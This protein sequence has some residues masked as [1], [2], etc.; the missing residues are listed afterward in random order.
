MR[1]L[2]N[3]IPFNEVTTYREMLLT[4]PF[5]Y[6]EVDSPGLPTTGMVHDFSP[7][8]EIYQKVLSACQKAFPEIADKTPYRAYLNLFMPHEKPFF[9]TD[10]EGITIL[11]YLNPPSSYD[12]GGETQFISQGNCIQG[13]LP[14]PG[15][16]V[17]FNALLL[18]R[19]TSFRTLT[20]LT[21]A[22]KYA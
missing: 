16:A 2:D 3:I 8:D 19:A 20:R 6:G 4:Y 7:D 1:Y 13:V 17:I 9:H 10:G 5:K 12:E 15:R 18:H 14:A 11:V 22:I 21:M